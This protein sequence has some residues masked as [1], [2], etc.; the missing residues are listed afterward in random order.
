LCGFKE[1]KR[2]NCTL[3]SPARIA[4]KFK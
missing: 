1:V 4:R 2:L 3:R